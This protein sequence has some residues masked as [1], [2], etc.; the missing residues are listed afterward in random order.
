MNPLLHLPSH[1]L[2][3]CTS[4]PHYPAKTLSIS[5]SYIVGTVVQD[6]NGI[7]FLSIPVSTL[8]LC[9]DRYQDKLI[10][11]HGLKKPIV[12]FCRTHKPRLGK[13]SIQKSAQAP[14]S[15]AVDRDHKKTSPRLRGPRYSFRV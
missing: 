6:P 14:T 11:A 10:R 13:A 12:T 5:A 9:Q 2:T 4:T 3:T 15:P 8:S 7:H 1:T